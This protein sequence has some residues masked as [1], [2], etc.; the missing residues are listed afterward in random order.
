MNKRHK[1]LSIAFLS[2]FVSNIKINVYIFL[3]YAKIFRSNSR[4]WF[5]NFHISSVVRYAATI[6]VSRQSHIAVFTP[7]IAPPVLQDP[8]GWRISDDE[9]RMVHHVRT[10][11][12]IIVNAFATNGNIGLTSG[13]FLCNLKRDRTLLL[14][15]KYD[16]YH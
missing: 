7:T 11:S 9:H 4:K 13:T 1:Q 2:Q 3:R 5:S 15:Y 6:L 12:M 8:L 14:K 16:S 10:A